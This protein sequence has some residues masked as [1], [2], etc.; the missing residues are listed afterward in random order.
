M[1][2][3]WLLWKIYHF[4]KN[5]LHGLVNHKKLWV[6]KQTRTTFDLYFEKR[7]KQTNKQKPKTKTNTH[8]LL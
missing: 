2:P 8:L 7:D 4:A 6:H 3:E 5:I 1:I